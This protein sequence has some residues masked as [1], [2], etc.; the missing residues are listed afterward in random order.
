MALRLA[1]TGHFH[2][3]EQTRNTMKLGKSV[4]V[5]YIVFVTKERFTAVY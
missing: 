1:D 2:E 3:W 5:N 4:Y